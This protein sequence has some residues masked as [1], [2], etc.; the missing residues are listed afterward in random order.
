LI[1]FEKACFGVDMPE[2]H[3][4]PHA[5]RLLRTVFKEYSEKNQFFLVTHS[6]VFIDPDKLEN[7]IVVKNQNGS[8]VIKQLA[9]VPSV[10]EKARL[11]RQLDEEKLDFF[12]SRAVLI[13]EGETEK[14]AMPL[15][16][17]KVKDFDKHGVTVIWAGSQFCGLFI[18]ILKAFDFPYLVMTDKDA[19][20]N[21]CK[22]IKCDGLPVSTSALFYNINQYLKMS[23][24]EKIKKTEP[25]IKTIG[26]G[27][28]QRRVYPDECFDE[29]SHI[30]LKYE[31][32]VLTSDFEGILKRDGYGKQLSTARKICGRNSSKVI[33]GRYVAER[34]LE[35]NLD[36]PQE[37]KAIIER[38]IEKCSTF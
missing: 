11:K 37:F 18:K 19:L 7:V 22:S 33:C 26:Q 32:H 23:D 24:C 21:I 3:L 4:H 27:K 20:M 38:V 10:D 14:G 36:I 30:A 9:E 15:L 12:F 6:P 31:I 34:I 17:K 35:D 28:K 5:E 25:K 2:L 29:L 1:S 13:V 8:T 16:S